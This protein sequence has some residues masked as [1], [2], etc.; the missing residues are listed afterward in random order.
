MGLPLFT[1]DDRKIAATK[2]SL[3]K[4]VQWAA[5]LLA[6]Y[7]A[8]YFAVVAWR[9]IHSHAPT[10]VDGPILDIME[11]FRSG[12]V[13]QIEGLK[14]TPY[15]V[16]THTPLSYVVDYLFYRLWPGFAA[17][18]LI[19]LLVTLA[20][21]VLIFFW[22]RRRTKS[23][24]SSLFA[25]C[26][27][28]LM[29]PVFQW[30]QVARSPDAFCCLFSLAA[31][32]MLEGRGRHRDILIGLL[33]TLAF[34]SKQTAAATLLP[35]LVISEY[36]I[37]RSVRAAFTWL[38]VFAGIIVPLFLWLQRMTHGGFWVDTVEAN[39]CAF[40]PWLFQH[41][42]GVLVFFWIFGVL[43]FALSGKIRTPA[44]VWTIVSV[45]V[46]L[47]TCGKQ[48]ADTMYFFDASAAVALLSGIAMARASSKTVAVL[49]IA[50]IPCVLL[51][52]V[53]LAHASSKAVEQSY[54]NMVNDLRPYPTILSDEPSIDILTGR[55]WY[56]GDPMV[57]YQLERA[58]KW[59]SS[60][61]ERGLKTHQFS[62]LIVW[63]RNAWSPK[64]LATLN[65]EYRI[66]KT[67]PAFKG[68]YTVY[69]P[70]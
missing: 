43:A 34:L 9:S 12:R 6:T 67:Y 56:W 62:A 21:A 50:L 46:G 23:L 16:L 70:R 57:L 8:G 26:V 42:I 20:C 61:I 58:G 38:A 45:A 28:L 32:T 15:T 40:S 39:V 68:S 19:N 25:V 2:A 35:A 54:R 4:A 55:P 18:R 3:P 10:W 24:P 29:P 37:R 60:F 33:F 36:L 69:L 51:S 59:D 63:N 1:P 7:F 17:L 44:H 22:V 66:W 13:Y 47:L 30:S 27:F 64:T 5:A 41:L 31:L 11:S 65:H 49:V 14:T 52:D 48:G 53:A